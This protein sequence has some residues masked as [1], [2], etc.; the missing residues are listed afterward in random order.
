VLQVQG[1]LFPTVESELSPPPGQES[2]LRPSIS[3]L[4]VPA[5]KLLGVCPAI[6]LLLVATEWE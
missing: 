6:R 3:M 1:R 2:M 5:P 4:K